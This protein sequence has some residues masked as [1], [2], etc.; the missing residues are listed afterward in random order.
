[1]RSQDVTIFEENG[2]FWVMSNT[3]GISTFSVQGRGKNWWKL[4]QG[5]Q[6]PIEL[7]I[8]NDHGNHWAWEPSSMMSLDQYEMALRQVGEHFYKA[9]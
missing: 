3:G 6:I 7:K 8:V 4:D 9:S 5:A 2:E 1:M